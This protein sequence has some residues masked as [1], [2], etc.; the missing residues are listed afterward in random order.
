MP[1]VDQCNLPNEPFRGGATYKT[2]NGDQPGSTPGRGGNRN[3]WL[4]PSG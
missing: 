2:G 3:S 4:S 1:V